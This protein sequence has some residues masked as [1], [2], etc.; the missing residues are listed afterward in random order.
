[1]TYSVLLLQDAEDDIF[2]I[3]QYIKSSDSLEAAEHVFCM[4]EK[5]CLSLENLPARGHVP[6]ELASINVTMFLEVL[7]KPYRVIYEIDKNNVFVHCVLDGRRELQQIL[8][9]RLLR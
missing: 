2:D 7:H 6:I 5:L 4:L 9:R 8:E 3:Y 1:M